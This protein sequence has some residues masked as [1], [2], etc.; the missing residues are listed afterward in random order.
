ML[1]LAVL[2]A[3]VFGTGMFFLPETPRWLLARDQGERARA[4]LVS[5]RG[6]EEVDREM[7]EVRLSLAEQP[8]RGR[9]P[10]LLSRAVRPALVVG[11][12][13]AVF[14]QITGSNTVIDYAPRILQT[15]GLPSAAG[16]IMATAGI[17]VVNVLMTLVAL[18]LIDRVGRRPLLLTGIAGMI[19]TLAAPPLHSLRLR[20]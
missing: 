18:W 9:W 17:G 4:V 3:L 12:G 6:T 7:T 8:E 19:V 5:I 16:A 15:A 13:L 2:P 20:P 11:L 10:D 1:G 14:Q